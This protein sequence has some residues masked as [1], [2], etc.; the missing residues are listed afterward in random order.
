MPTLAPGRVACGRT[1]CWGVPRGMAEGYHGPVLGEG[2]A[3]FG[4]WMSLQSSSN[5]VRIWVKIWEEWALGAKC[6]M[7]PSRKSPTLIATLHGSSNREEAEHATNRV[8]WPL[9]STSPSP[10]ATPAVLQRKRSGKNT[11]ELLR[12]AS[13]ARPRPQPRRPWDGA[14]HGAGY[15]GRARPGPGAVRR[16]ARPRQGGAGP[17]LREQLPPSRSRRER[18]QAAVRSRLRPGG[19]SGCLPCA[20][21]R[22]KATARA[23]ASLSAPAPAPRLRGYGEEDSGSRGVPV[24]PPPPPP[25]RS[26]TGPRGDVAGA[27]QRE[28]R[29]SAAP[30]RS[31]GSGAGGPWGAWWQPRR[32]REWWAAARP[33]T[34]GQTAAASEPA[35]ASPHAAAAAPPRAREGAPSPALVRVTPLPRRSF[36]LSFPGEAAAWDGTGR[37]AAGAAAAACP[38]HLVQ[39]WFMV[40]LTQHLARRACGEQQRAGVLSFCYFWKGKE[41][42][43]WGRGRPSGIFQIADPHPVFPASALQPRSQCGQQSVT[44][45]R[46]EGGGGE[47]PPVKV[48]QEGKTTSFV[49]K[50]CVFNLCI[51][52]YMNIYL[53]VHGMYTHTFLSCENVAGR[54]LLPDILFSVSFR[55]ICISAGR[56]TDSSNVAEYVFQQ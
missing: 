12:T 37:E 7:F 27:Q 6:L 43:P 45:G 48:W 24:S 10:A 49:Q 33:A 50:P 21:L 36:P 40:L 11:V 2:K 23:A 4:L 3:L 44:V 34:P 19:R 29:F 5:C 22:G 47:L 18:W 13:T 14:E 54:L 42:G 41:Q 15:G 46:F 38:L 17:P 1:G 56:G 39:R 25:P 55:H 16:G 30:G 28:F 31:R 53:C 52:T 32:L 20:P 51:Y 26:R 9:C 8:F 35:S